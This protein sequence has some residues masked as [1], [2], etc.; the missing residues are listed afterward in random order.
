MARFGSVITAMVTPFAPDGSLDLDAAATVA[1]HLAAS[2]S[3]GL[4]VA[5]TTGEGP[6]LTDTE[7]IDL[8]RAVVEA[9][10]IPV[11][12]STGTNDTAHSVLMTREAT[13][14]GVDGILAVTP[15]YN[16][17]SAAGLAAHFRAIAEASD[18]P[19]LLYDIPIRSGRRIGPELTLALARE[20]PS[21]VGVKDATGDVASAAIVVAESPDGFDVYCG[22]DS[23]T[24]P[25]ESIGGA[26]VISVAS[27]W[28]GRLFA[29]LI[30]SHRAG[31]V[32]RAVLVNQHLSESYRFESSDEF[33]NP[34]PAK[35]ACR[36][37]GLPVGQCRLPNAPAPATLDRRAEAVIATVRQRY[38]MHQP[39]A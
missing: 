35:A 3:D 7:R 23:L 37:M 34:V 9:V 17:P 1:G 30:A 38:P 33:P 15:Y 22:D 5:G 2:G 6:V 21:I 8:F 39:V 12:A 32:E 13:A 18:L 19:V 26:G 31:D 27:H 11:I 28:A 14:V 4:V 20:V 25:F 10:D 29:E 24:L 36:A 16:R